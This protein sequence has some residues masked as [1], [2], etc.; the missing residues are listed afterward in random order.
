MLYTP[1]N[2]TGVRV[3]EF[4]LPFTAQGEGLS[5]CTHVAAE[6]EIE[7]LESRMLY[8]RKIF[9]RCK[10]SISL[11]R[12]FPFLQAFAPFARMPSRLSPRLR[13]AVRTLPFPRRAFALK[14]YSGVGGDGF[15][16]SS[17]TD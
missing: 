3:L 16:I 1:E 11:Q 7:L 5:D 17:A 14:V 15:E 12:V 8:P 9:T 4:A 6:T 2:E 13:C 10:L